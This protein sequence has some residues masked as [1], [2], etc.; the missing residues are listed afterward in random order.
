M[1]TRNV[2]IFGDPLIDRRFLLKLLGIS[3][4][5]N[6]N[7]LPLLTI[8]ETQ[9]H[10]VNTNRNQYVL[11]NTAG[12]HSDVSNL[13]PRELLRNL[14]RFTRA[15]DGGINLLIYVIDDNHSVHNI[16]LFHDFFCRRDAPII[17]VTSNSHPPS[18]SESD[19]YLPR[20]AAVLTLTGANLE[21][22]KHDIQETIS[23]NIK[24]DP[25]D[26]LP[27][28]RF[29]MTATRSWQLLERAAGWSVPT[30]QDALKAT[31]MEEAFF[32]DQDASAKCQDIADYIKK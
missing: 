20:F 31:L 29:E 23:M 9:T 16:C 22:D 26:I 30:W 12:L 19:K 25:K 21:S 11:Y 2:I 1:V 10:L 15:I 32:S 8:F 5:W 14:H 27:I 17:L 4:T 13:E 24:R 7:V 3:V 28:D 18:R 6:P